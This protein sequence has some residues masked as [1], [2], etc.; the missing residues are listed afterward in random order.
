VAV[1]RD[2]VLKEAQRLLER[3]RYDKAILEYEKLVAEDPQDVRTLLQIGDLHLKIQQYVE[4]A[5]SYE[6]VAE[7]YAAQPAARKK[8]IAVYKRI[9]E[10]VLKFAPQA[11][12]R[13]EHILPRLAELYMQLG[14]TNEA[15]AVLEEIGTRMQRAGKDREALAI[16]NKLVALDPTSPLPHLRLA[17]GYV[18]A[19]DFENAIQRFGMA[20]EILLK[21]GRRDD[22]LKVV[23]RLLQHRAVPRFARIAAEIYLDRGQEGDGMAALGKLQISFKDNPKHIETL[24]LLARAFDKLNQPEKALEVQKEAARIAKE[25]GKQEQFQALLEALLA[26]APNDEGVRQLAAQTRPPTPSIPAVSVEEAPEEAP[27]IEEEEAEVELDEA[28]EVILD[29]DDLEIAPSSQVPILLTPSQAPPPIT[30]DPISR[31]RQIMAQVEKYRASK[32]YDLAAA[33]L[34]EGINEIP[35][36]RDLRER[37]CDLL[38]ESG[39]TAEAVRQMVSF[40]RWLAQNGD[41]E[42]AA[43]IL[44]ETLLL[45]PNQPHAI[46]MLRELGYAVGPQYEEQQAYSQQADYTAQQEYQQQAYAQQAYAQQA[47][48]QQG[49]PQQGYSQQVDY[50]AQQAYAAVGYQDPYGQPVA[51]DPNTQQAPGYDYPAIPGALPF[52]PAQLD[53]PFAADA[54]LPSFSLEDEAAAAAAAHHYPQPQH[55]SGQHVAA[56]YNAYAAY[57]QRTPSGPPGQLD[58]DALEEVEFF[59]ANGM[60]DEARNLLDE[61]LQR[62]PNHPLLLERK[63]ELEALAAQAAEASGTRA[64]P[65]AGPMGGDEVLNRID[66]A[67]NFIDSIEEIQDVS[68]LAN[69]PNQVSVEDV[70]AQFK[71]GV[72][73]QIS[74]SDAA[75]HY[76]LGVAYKEMG[77]SADAINEFELASR[78]PNR[79]CVCQ[80]MIG[81]IHLQMG[82]VEAAIDAFIRGLH[83]SLKTREQELALTYEIGDA[84]QGRNALDQALYYFQRVVRIDPNYADLRGTATERVRKLEAVLNK[85]APVAAPVRAAVGADV[86]GDE[87]DAALDDLLS[88]TELP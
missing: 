58:E 7:I 22:A 23:E 29:E 66:E 54:P 25:S 32:E 8:A 21:S 52:T 73:S 83:A 24:S 59:A 79:E 15:S 4:A 69:D 39:N 49:Y 76:D 53:D 57:P 3:K 82:N 18:R 55:E 78:D 16:F 13:F 68:G 48:A 37:F 65:R 43:R 70:F 19:R 50:A 35:S 56:H 14:Q 87:F 41:I 72:A 17:E 77:L 9:R 80:S 64:V 71:Q 61:Q 38:V 75:T 88:S 67:I 81:M 63:R 30:S 27:S 46:A 45:E 47:Y 11:E 20:A 1:D 6:R 40:A 60:F 36:S 51:Y 31:V 28:D 74:E 86:G 2:K 42:G 26:R 85:P 33:L 5:S 84:Y 44:D 12:D 34:L 10:I 62:L